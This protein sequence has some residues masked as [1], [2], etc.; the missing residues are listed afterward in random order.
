MRSSICPSA[1]RSVDLTPTALVASASRGDERAWAE[2]VTRYERLVR[3]VV[4]SYRMQEADAAD[5]EASTWLHAV[6][7]LSTLR[8]PARLGGWLRTIARRECLAVLRH[9]ML[10]E[11]AEAAVAAI[12]D[13]D[14]GPEQTVIGG[15][16]C[17]AIAE[18][19]DHLPRKGRRVILALFFLPE[20]AYSEM[21]AHTGMPVGSLGPT[22]MRALRTLRTDLEGAGFGPDALAAA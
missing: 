5:A 20:M 7:S 22:R 21:A 17:K 9:A 16:V 11:P 4:G 18:A 2:I 12:V 3:G 1:N 8:D 14:P 10:E 13:S 19:M 15:E 6:E